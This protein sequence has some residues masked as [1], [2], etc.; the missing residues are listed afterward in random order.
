[1][2]KI[3]SLVWTSG[4]DAFLF[5]FGVAAL[6]VLY[7]SLVPVPAA[8]GTEAAAPEGERRPTSPF[9]FE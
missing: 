4:V 6:L 2:L 9:V 7:R 3:P 1:M 5:P 8:P